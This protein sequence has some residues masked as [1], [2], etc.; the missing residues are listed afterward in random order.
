MKM[1]KLSLTLIVC[2]MAVIMVIS[3]CATKS[4]AVTEEPKPAPEEA[5]KEEAP[6]KA[7]VAEEKVEEAVVEEE[8]D[9]QI[10][11]KLEEVEKI[12]TYKY[13]VEFD[14]D[15]AMI[16]GNY[17][18][19]VQE[20]IDFL[21]VNPDARIIKI[22]IEGHTDNSGS[23]SYNY[24]LAQRR[25]N[26]VKQVLIDQ[27]NVDPEIIETRNYG[28]SKPIASNKTEAGRQKNRAAVVTILISR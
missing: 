24:A 18:K 4:K 25:I 23:A 3:G 26:S 11:D 10:V 1:L 14:L 15:S 16:R 6:E 17:F 12:T 19:N 8:P 27:L 5:V 28:E 2:M 21:E 22:T 20:A 7:E 9:I 13:S